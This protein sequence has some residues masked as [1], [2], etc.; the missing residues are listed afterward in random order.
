MCPSVTAQL[1]AQGVNY[2]LSKQL[3]LAAYDR[4]VLDVICIVIVVEFVQKLV[5][6]R[7]LCE[8]MYLY[9]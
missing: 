1:V 7:N 2:G 6:I 3:N 4:Y 8:N 5:A 9:G